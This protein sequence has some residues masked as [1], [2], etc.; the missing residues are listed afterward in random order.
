MYCQVWIN[1]AVRLNQYTDTY[2]MESLP[3]ISSATQNIYPWV[4]TEFSGT[5]L[6]YMV[7][8]TKRFTSLL[9]GAILGKNGVDIQLYAFSTTKM[10]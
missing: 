2:V 8:P 7:V 10:H 3:H 4:S 6:K 1:K 5:Q 9:S